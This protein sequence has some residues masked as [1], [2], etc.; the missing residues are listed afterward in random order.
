MS[1]DLLSRLKLDLPLV[2]APMAGVSGSALAIAVC[3]AG[4]LG[5]LPCAMLSLEQIRAEV[6]AIRAATP[7][8]F[9]LN[10][11]CHK[12]TVADE[13]REQRWR[14]KLHQYFLEFGLD[15]AAIATGGGRA[16]FDESHAALVEAL[17]PPVVS[18]H[19]GLP[20]AALLARVKATGALVLSSATTVAEA[21][22]LQAQGADVIIA[23]GV[24]AGGHRGMFLDDNLA[25]QLPLFSLLP[26]VLD[27]LSVP[28][29]AAG[30][31]SSV[32]RINDALSM[33]AAAIQA[34]SVF[35][36]C[37]ECNT[38]PL[39]RAA[40][41]KGNVDT[42]LTNVFSGKPARSIVNRL[43]TG[44]GPMCPDTS[45]F[46]YTGTALVPLRR[47]AEA[48]GRTDFSP[49]WCG[50]DPGI[51]AETPAGEIAKRLFSA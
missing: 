7:A 28:V 50:T 1:F 4:G 2:Q 47:A 48:L 44:L 13:K 29:I 31:M 18:F 27:A 17:K 32:S 36:L 49:L 20:H 25:T 43:I 26:A 22:W 51:C 42:A 37:P 6:S 9:N 10:F 40:I 12:P 21:R 5:S 8:A 30:G 14:T 39:H 19:F 23:Q 16:P 11:F 3:E 34:G 24:E 35:L 45:G 15:P 46:P 38:T 41:A 33:G